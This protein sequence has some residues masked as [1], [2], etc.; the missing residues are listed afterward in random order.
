VLFELLTGKRLY[1]SQESADGPRR[2]LNEPP[3]DLADYR[4]DAEPE[5]VAL[6]F[7]LLAKDRA[8]RPA[9]AKAVARRLE[10][11][12]AVVTAAG[13]SIETADFLARHFAAER[14]KLEQSIAA[15][16]QSLESAKQ[17][18]KRRASGRRGRV[19]LAASV[20]A[21]LTVAVAL[22][23]ALLRRP[24]AGPESLPVTAPSA[25]AAPLAAGTPPPEVVAPPATAAEPGAATTTAVAEPKRA[26]AAPK[27]PSEASK[28]KKTG[29][30]MWESY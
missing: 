23:T 10:A 5:L 27:K 22:A 8:A 3:P 29:V 17:G 24:V 21:A 11:V 30:R 15:A 1:R 18:A 2:I 28:N 25:P 9:T 12:L 14:Q 4:D 20:A 6:L 7:E 26:R 13:A 19:L 16:R